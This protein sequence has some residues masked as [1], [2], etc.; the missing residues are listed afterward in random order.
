MHKKKGRRFLAVCVGVLAAGML[1]G[2]GSPAER[3]PAEENMYSP[4]MSAQDPGEGDVSQEET[5]EP[6]DWMQGGYQMPWGVKGYRECSCVSTYVLDIPEPEFVYA[7]KRSRFYA[8]LGGDF[9]VLDC[10]AMDE[11]GDEN[12][13]WRYQLY[14]LDGDTG[15]GI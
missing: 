2:C 11:A 4:E 6:V 13:Q 7:E 12:T 5:W 3:E 8:S 9:Y 14:W 10:Y 1:A 15:D